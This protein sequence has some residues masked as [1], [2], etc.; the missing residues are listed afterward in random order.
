MIKGGAATAFTVR[1]DT[2][3]N[4][5]RRAVSL[6]AQRSEVLT[7]AQR[8]GR[9]WA[10]LC[11]ADPTSSKGSARRQGPQSVVRTPSAA[12]PHMPTVALDRMIL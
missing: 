9:L 12:R 8:A 10:V 11:N 4:D 7:T 1:K 3:R 2:L 5:H 6:K